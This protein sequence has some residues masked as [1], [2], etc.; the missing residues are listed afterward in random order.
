MTPGLVETESYR[1][2]PLLFFDA[3]RAVAG[4]RSDPYSPHTGLAGTVVPWERTET[5]RR[6]EAVVGVDLRCE[7]DALA[8]DVFV[9]V[10][11]DVRMPSVPGEFAIGRGEEE[12]ALDVV[13]A[14]E[15]D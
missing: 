6:E 3:T 10:G 7:E 15:Q 4:A 2:A 12:V 13:L 11:I 8:S 9:L 1:R 5:L 14:N